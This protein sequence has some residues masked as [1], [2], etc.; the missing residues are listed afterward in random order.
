MPKLHL[1]FVPGSPIVDDWNGFLVAHFGPKIIER[2]ERLGGRLTISLAVP[3][4][5]KDRSIKSPS[6]DDNE[7]ATIRGLSV[8][9]TALQSRLDTYDAKNLRLACERLGIAVSKK[10]P[11]IELIAE[12][13]R[14]LNSNAMWEGISRVHGA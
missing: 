13:M 11:R 9:K 7:L 14:C 3:F 10:V 12:I 2:L 4:I 5:P 6:F 1:D 8:D